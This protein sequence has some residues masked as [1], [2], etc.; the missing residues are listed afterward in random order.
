MN[1][2]VKII[3]CAVAT[4]TTHAS[5]ANLLSNASFESGDLT[6]WNSS[7]GIGVVVGSSLSMNP[8]T[9]F[10]G[11]YFFSASRTD[12][13][14]YG[15]SKIISISQLVGLDDS[16]KFLSAGGYFSGAFGVGNPSNDLAQ[17]SLSFFAAGEL[18]ETVATP[19]IDPLVGAWNHLTLN[20]IAVPMGATHLIFEVSTF[21]DPGFS[22]ID[23]G[24]D[25]LI[26]SAVPEPTAIYLA[27]AGVGAIALRH[28]SRAIRKI[29]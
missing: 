14:S 22:S 26:L 11:S 1:Q 28:N 6:S 4:L 7:A 10:G 23:I 29:A 27:L 13:A 2:A 16:I 24:V 18:I 8:S 21:L 20:S 5:N 15:A 9:P 3:V 25:E 17:I 19:K 12:G